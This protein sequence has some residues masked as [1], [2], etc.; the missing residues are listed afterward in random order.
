MK[1]KTYCPADKPVVNVKQRK[2]LFQLLFIF[3]V[4]FA[5]SFLVN[6]N[7]VHS[8]PV[9]LT[10][11]SSM[12][13]R[14]ASIMVANNSYQSLA[15]VVGDAGQVAVY[16]SSGRS[17]LIDPYTFT[18]GNATASSSLDLTINDIPTPISVTSFSPIISL[19]SGAKATLE[20]GDHLVSHTSGE[21]VL[22]GIGDS[23]VSASAPYFQIFIN[24][25]ASDQV[26][27]DFDYIFTLGGTIQ[28]QDPLANV[29]FGGTPFQASASQ[30]FSSNQI[31]TG[32]IGG[33]ISQ[34]NDYS[35]IFTGTLTVQL[36][37]NSLN[38]VSFYNTHYA[39]GHIEDPSTTTPVP[40][41]STWLLLG[42]GLAGLAAW[43]RRNEK[44][45]VS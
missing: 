21:I 7:N 41:P 25:A 24:N 27:V 45:R 20:V 18:I 42:S 31:S 8:A 33:H 10:T 38:I 32:G 1:R 2:T 23:A 14:V 16:A 22:N 6:L 26:I 37:T 40:E 29:G 36:N 44:T 3:I 13:V 19:P 12:D 39:S 4:F 34:S 5:C 17:G 30:L 9:T 11:Y 35:N 28:G 43:R 15:E